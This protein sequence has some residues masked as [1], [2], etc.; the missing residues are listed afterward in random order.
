MYKPSPTALQTLAT[1]QQQA[2]HDFGLQS[3]EA[4][5]VIAGAEIAGFYG[6]LAGGLS[7]DD[8]ERWVARAK[9]GIEHAYAATRVTPTQDPLDQQLLERIV[10]EARQRVALIGNASF[11]ERTLVGSLPIGQMNAFTLHIPETD[12]YL[13]LFQRGLFGLLNLLARAITSIWPEGPPGPGAPLLASRDVLAENLRKHPDPA[14]YLVAV[15]EHA[16]IRGNP[17]GFPVLPESTARSGMKETLLLNAE[18]FILGH[19]YGH[20][21]R[22]H[23]EPQRE[24]SVTHG[25]RAFS[26][27]S[28]SH[29][30][31]YA[32]DLTGFEYA[33]RFGTLN[34]V[35]QYLAYCGTCLFLSCQDLVED[36]LTLLGGMNDAHRARDTHPAGARRREAICN[37]L[38]FQIGNEN[39]ELLERGYAEM[40]W[41]LEEFWRLAKPRWADLVQGGAVASPI[42]ATAVESYERPSEDEVFTESSPDTTTNEVGMPSLREMDSFKGHAFLALLDLVAGDKS[43]RHVA[44]EWMISNAHIVVFSLVS[45]L[46]YGNPDRR[47]KFISY[48]VEQCPGLSHWISTLRFVIGRYPDNSDLAGVPEVMIAMNVGMLYLVEIA[49]RIQN[50]EDVDYVRMLFEIEHR[51]HH[52][53]FGKHS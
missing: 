36:A 17:S 29:Q 42:W 34:P 37:V 28:R 26:A 50:G 45:E 9:E 12:E 43:R 18:V 33:N 8:A 53:L 32:A 52:D 49:R 13:I 7:D 15:L 27:T 39:A 19:E 23:F 2:L 14:G 30:Q 5:K 21:Q 35:Q 1:L 10:E 25:N 20:I 47:D 3:A 11:P 51:V 31:E 24:V 40:H 6:R 4:S 16:L 48:L 38:R 44:A 46:A 22:N 41:I